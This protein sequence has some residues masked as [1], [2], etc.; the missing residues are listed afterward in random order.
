MAEFLQRLIT[1][2]RLI[3]LMLPLALR[4]RFVRWLVI[5]HDTLPI[6]RLPADML[7]SFQRLLFSLFCTRYD[8]SPLD[9]ADA[10]PDGIAIGC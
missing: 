7:L 4:F 3:R 8:M 9:F 1:L 6:R 2:L 5:P 10:T